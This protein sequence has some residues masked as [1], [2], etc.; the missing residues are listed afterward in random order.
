VADAQQIAPLLQPVPAGVEIDG[1]DAV[2]VG[3]VP[4]A[5]C[6]GRP[7]DLLQ[8]AARHRKLEFD[9]AV[10]IHHVLSAV[11]KGARSVA[12]SR[13]RPAVFGACGSGLRPDRGAGMPRRGQYFSSTNSIW[14]RLS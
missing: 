6:Q 2:L 9:F 1:A 11:L 10:G 3:A 5:G 14:R 12:R 13:Q 7:A 8:R 4:G